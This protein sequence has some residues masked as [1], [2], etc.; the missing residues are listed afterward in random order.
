MFCKNFFFLFAALL[1]LCTAESLWV[2]FMALDLD[3]SRVLLYADERRILMLLLLGIIFCLCLPRAVFFLYIIFQFLSNLFILCY[4]SNIGSPPLL[5]SLF[6][7]IQAAAD[8]GVWNILSFVSLKYVALLAASLAAKLFLFRLYCR[9]KINRKIQ[10]SVA[11][12]ALAGIML[13]HVHLYKRME[14]SAFN[15]PLLGTISQDGAIVAGSESLMAL[16]MARQVGLATTWLGEGLSGNFTQTGSSLPANDYSDFDS[17]GLPDLELPPTIVMIQVESFDY[18]LLDIEVDGEPVM[19]FL[20]S[21]R[22]ASMII[23]VNMRYKTG[24]QNSDYEIFSGNPAIFPVIYYSFLPEYIFADF[25]I[26]KIKARGYHTTSFSNCSPETFSIKRAYDAMGFEQSYWDEDFYTAYPQAKMASMGNDRLM[27]DFAATKLNPSDK[28][29]FFLVTISM[30]LPFIN[31]EQVNR[32]GRASLWEK[33]LST[34]FFVDEAMRDFYEALPE[35]ALLFIWGDHPS[36]GDFAA[37]L[38]GAK[39]V[40]FMITVKGADISVPHSREPL[41]S[42]NE[43]GIYLRRLFAAD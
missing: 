11:A 27:F 33:Y 26:A 7:S 16:F 15:F 37:H 36:G 34:A 13:F 23:P 9:L 2:D 12:A 21:L 8:L 42:L 17:T 10:W 5:I 35:G 25:L 29:F 31:L 22:P 38:A 18:C 43:T 6:G 4:I 28:Q 30:H 40:P 1:G 24:S 3:I 20:H 32:F 14:V 19:P 39:S 41:N